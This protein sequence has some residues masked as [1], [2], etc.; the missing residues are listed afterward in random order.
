MARAVERRR[1]PTAPGRR[2]FQQAGE[3][4]GHEGIP[5]AGGIHRLHGVARHRAVPVRRQ[6]HTPR[7]APGHGHEAQ[8]VVPERA[9]ARHR[10]IQPGEEAHLVLADLD[11][12]GVAQ[13]EPHPVARRLRVRPEGEAQV[14]V[15]AH[16]QA[17]APG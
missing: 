16:A 9:H 13:A 4:P 8:I 3:Q 2:P 6:P 12:L 15:V 7:R 1:V 5:G 11:D 10:V 17:V 14:G